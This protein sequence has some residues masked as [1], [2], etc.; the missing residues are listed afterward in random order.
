MGEPDIRDLFEAKSVA[1]IGASQSKEKIGY[2]VLE[3]IVNGGFAGAVY[4]VNPSGG[5]ILGKKV[6]R[7]IEE[8][9][10]EVD[11]ACIV[12]PAKFVFDAVGGCAKKKV[13]FVLIISS[14]FSDVGNNEEEAKIVAFAKENKMRILG[15]NIFGV[16]S[17]SSSLNCTFGPGAIKKGGIAIITQSGALGLSMI[18]KTAV[19]NMGLSAIV[20]VGNKADVDESD[21]LSYLVS[22]E[23]TKVI[24]VY[25]EGVHRGERLLAALKE[26]TKKKPVVVI[27]SGRSEKGAIAAASHTGSLAGSDEVFD[28]VIRQCGV[29]RAEGV[30]E[31]FD[32]CKFL[33]NSPIP[34]KES[35]L[36]ITNGGGIGVMAADACEKYGV[37][38]YDDPRAL[39][40][41]FSNVTPDFGSTKNPIDLTGQATSV[42]YYA[43]LDTALAD[44]E[45]SSVVAL[46]CET[47]V[48][49]SENLAKLIRETYTRYSSAK[50]PLIFSIFGGERTENAIEELRRESVS[51]F[52]D[53]YDAVSCVGALYAYRKGKL[54]EP[55]PDEDAEIN[56][57]AIE[58]IAKK[59]LSEGRE[60]LLAHEAKELAKVIGIKVP[61]SRVARSLEEAIEKAEEIDYPVVMK[62]VS[63][64]ILHKSDVGGIALNLESRGEVIDAYEAVIHS[65]KARRPDAVIEGVEIS[66]MV[67][68]GT[69]LIIGARNDR[70]FGP[71]AMFG[72]GGVYVEV[73]KDV[74]FRA[75]PLSKKEMT[76]MMKDVKSYSL[77]LGVRGQERRDIDAVVG[78]ITKIGAIIRKCKSITDIEINPLVVYGQGEGVQAVDIRVMLLSLNRGGN[79]G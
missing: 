41:K 31:A 20:S 65:C 25:I 63:K 44:D 18:G 37:R 60:S 35:T 62:I 4:P 5:E 49:D 17:G 43:A 42:Q 46:Y 57:D 45:I 32:W 47:A 58:A 8:I 15:P 28:D 79:N 33:A 1:V 36:I 3:N 24:L 55:A 70:V 66:K 73:M 61:E 21:L 27:K 52:S 74:S 10:G 38:L 11:V 19:E 30:K 26:A 69:E 22:Q 14:G 39:K 56:V 72:L 29:I 13:K 48:F 51:V 7:T 76:R 64:D 40:E 53:V 9:E 67:K 75:L 71:I 54:D 77:L 78:A 34:S 50:K 16:Y 12:I 23:S 6:Y 59:A 2:K 68:P